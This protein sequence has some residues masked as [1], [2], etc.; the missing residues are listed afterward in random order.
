M[1][2][3]S[4]NTGTDIRKTCLE[5]TVSVSDAY[6]VGLWGEGHYMYPSHEA[7]SCEESLNSLLLQCY[8]SVNFYVT[9]DTFFACS[10]YHAR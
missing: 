4:S 7:N 8:G 9:R 1:L 10:P 2:A 6:L 3:S 5:Q